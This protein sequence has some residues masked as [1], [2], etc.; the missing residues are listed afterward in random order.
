LEKVLSTIV[1]QV[2]EKPADITIAVQNEKIRIR[3]SSTI[4]KPRMTALQLNHNQII[5]NG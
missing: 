4:I 5:A 2:L 3:T 1:W